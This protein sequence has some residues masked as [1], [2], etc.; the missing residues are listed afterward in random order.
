MKKLALLLAI[1]MIMSA[2]LVSCSKKNKDNDDDEVKDPTIIED[3]TGVEGNTNE[4]GSDNETGTVGGTNVTPTSFTF[5]SCAEISVYTIGSVNIRKEASFAADVA[6]KAVVDG[7]ELV[8]IG[9]SNESAIDS[10]GFEYKWFKVKYE[11]AEWYVKSTLVTSMSNPDEGFEPV[12]KTLYVNTQGLSVRQFPNTENAPVA[13]LTFGDVV[14]VIAENTAGG[15]Y[16][17]SYEGK[18]VKGEYYIISDAKYFSA[19]P[20]ESGTGAEG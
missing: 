19:T 1:L 4:L 18:Y 20:V 13:Y 6:K 2:M 5:K 14:N 3:E 8:K 12:T 15:W 17:I 7:T 16:K 9:E 11:D 10:D